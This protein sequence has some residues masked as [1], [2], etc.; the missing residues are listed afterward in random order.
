MLHIITHARPDLGNPVLR[1]MHAARKRVFV[2]LLG[3][4]IPVRDD[5]Y[6][7]DDFDTQ[8]AIYLVLTGPG[9]EHRASARLLPTTAPHILDTLFSSLC[10]G[11]VP[12]GSDTYEITRFCLDRAL[13]AR[14][15]RRARNGLVAALAHHAPQLGIARYTG[16][17]ERGWLEQILAFGWHCHLLG[18]TRRFGGAELGA[19]G[20]EINAATPALLARNGICPGEAGPEDVRDAA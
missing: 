14:E 10:E 2:D 11:P 16:V 15:R 5:H 3:W 1:T 6:E 8:A 4:Q 17:A 20:I 13:P 7:I 19:L 9:G 18:P 12:R